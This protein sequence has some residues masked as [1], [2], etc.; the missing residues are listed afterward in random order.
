MT[1]FAPKDVAIKMNLLLYRILISRLICKKGLALFLF[2]HRTYVLDIC[3]N[4]LS[5]A[6]LKYPNHMFL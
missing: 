1:A 2:P 3:Y 6:I 5:E 4:R